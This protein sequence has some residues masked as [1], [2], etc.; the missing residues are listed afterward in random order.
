MR[1]MNETMSAHRPLA[2]GLVVMTALAMLIA[3]GCATFVGD[4]ETA[5]DGDGSSPSVVATAVSPVTEPTTAPTTVTLEPVAEAE[6]DRGGGEDHVELFSSAP[7][8]GIAFDALNIELSDQ[9]DFARIDITKG[10]LK[11][12]VP[13][14]AGAFVTQPD[15]EL[16]LGGRVEDDGVVSSAAIV[17]PFGTAV[18]LS[19]VLT[20]MSITIEDTDA[21]IDAVNEALVD[22]DG[23]GL[24][25]HQYLVLDGR[26]VLLEVVD[27]DG[28]AHLSAVVSKESTPAAASEAAAALRT[29]MAERL[30]A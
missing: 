25:E 15:P 22:L 21:N 8:F 12:P 11:L 2:S 9:F 7:V 26:G 28:A 16:L 19:A 23:S 24:G 17:S 27:I 3:A 14:G 13:E 4:T 30:A 6:P 1:S 20:L 29:A 5:T 18:S 10:R